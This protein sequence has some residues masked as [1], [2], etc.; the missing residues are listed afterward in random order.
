MRVDTRKAF[1][2]WRA[3]KDF[4]VTIVKTTTVEKADPPQK[5]GGCFVFWDF[6]G[7]LWPDS[8]RAV[9][10]LVKV[11]TVTTEKG[12]KAKKVPPSD[13]CLEMKQEN[14]KHPNTTPQNENRPFFWGGVALNRLVFFYQGL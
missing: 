6:S 7:G 3:S 9:P 2:L 13:V 12:N 5:K 11:V 14:R 8:F 10:V 1:F 4:R